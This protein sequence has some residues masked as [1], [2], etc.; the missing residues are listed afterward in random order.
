MSVFQSIHLQN[1]PRLDIKVNNGI[2]NKMDEAR[3][4]CNCVFSLRKDANIRV[5]MPLKKIIICGKSNISDEYIELIKQEVNAHEVEFFDGDI[6]EI[7]TCSIELN[8]KECGKLLGSRLRDVLTAQKEG[9]WQIVNNKLKIAGIELEN[10]LFTTSYKTKEGTKAMSC[11]S[12]MLVLID[13][14][15]T[16]ELIME[17][18]SRDV[19]RIV[20]QTRKDNGY[21]INDRIN[22]ALYSEDK[23]FENVLS[24]WKN[25]ICKQTLADDIKFYNVKNKEDGAF[26]EIDN[27]E[28]S[29]QLSKK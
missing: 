15:Q 5:R 20:Q 1:F 12:N 29:L 26:Y 27:H 11:N 10:N 2:V 17:G 24:T 8:M 28:F 3:E 25:Y 13:T 19:V 16:Q 6:N 9:K 4:I 18:L 22:I 7:A 21:K 23:I 14:T